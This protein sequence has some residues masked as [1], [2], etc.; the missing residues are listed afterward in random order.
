ME[1]SRH[2]YTHAADFIRRLGPVNGSGVVLSRGDASKIRQGIAEV[3]NM[4]DYELACKLSEAQQA[5]NNDPDCAEKDTARL[6]A[7][8]MGQF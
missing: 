7:A 8:I 3:L 4:D 6:L 1:S 5:H 2:P